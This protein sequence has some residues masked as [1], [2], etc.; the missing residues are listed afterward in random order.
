MPVAV[1]V[2]PLVR[3]TI[4]S[5]TTFALETILPVAFTTP[6]VVKLPPLTLPVTVRDVNV[7][8]LVIFG[9]AFVYTVPATNAL[10][11][12]PDTLAP[13]TEFAVVANVAKLAVP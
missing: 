3:P 1:I 2:T 7:P 9:C 6:L 5:V 4:K 12:C 8:T 11:T 10:A 13:A